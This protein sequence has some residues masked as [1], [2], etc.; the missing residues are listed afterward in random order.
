LYL[1][2]HATRDG[3]QNNKNNHWNIFGPRVN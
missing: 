1:N 3:T 2:F